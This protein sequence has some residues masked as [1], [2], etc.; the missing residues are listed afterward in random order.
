MLARK[1]LHGE[2]V[3]V[4]APHKEGVPLVHAEETIGQTAHLA[5]GELH[6]I[7]TPGADGDGCLADLGDGQ[8]EEL[9][10]FRFALIPDAEGV[11][12]LRLVDDPDDLMGSGHGNVVHISSPSLPSASPP[13]RPVFQRSRRSGCPWGSAYRS[14]RSQRTYCPCRSGHCSQTAC[15]W[16]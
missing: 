5:D 12:R 7:R 9:T 10:V 15:A 1:T 13:P 14:G 2:G 16:P 6:V 11:L 8:H 3:A 4:G